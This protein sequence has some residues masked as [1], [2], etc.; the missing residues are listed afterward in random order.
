M[1]PGDPAE[2]VVESRRVEAAHLHAALAQPAEQAPPAEAH[3]AQPVVDDP[4]RHALVRLGD[5]GLDEALADLVGLDRVHLAVDART[6]AADRLQP[7]RIV[8]TRVLEQAHRV[9]LHERR[10]RGPG[11]DLVG[12]H[13]RPP[14]HAH[15]CVG[16][17]QAAAPRGFLEG[18]SIREPGTRFRTRPIARRARAGRPV[19]RTGWRRSCVTPGNGLP[20]VVDEQPCCP[21]KPRPPCCCGRETAS[22]TGSSTGRWA[23]VPWAPSTAST[24]R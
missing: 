4:H 18:E 14:G 6:G 12:E 11:E 5:E 13:A 15:R 10:A 1:V 22:R 8:L 3:R 17:V 16:G 21:L 24:R 9:A 19:D 7:G 23:R 2:R 20:F